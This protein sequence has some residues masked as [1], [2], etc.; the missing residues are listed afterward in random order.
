MFISI[1]KPYYPNNPN[2][3]PTYMNEGAIFSDGANMYFYGGALSRTNI[4]TIPPPVETW[5]YTI[6]T[7]TWNN[8]GFGGAPIVR[9]CFLARLQERRQNEP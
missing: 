3:N 4:T 1:P 5:Q 8:Q 9:L 7:D 2:A 6:A